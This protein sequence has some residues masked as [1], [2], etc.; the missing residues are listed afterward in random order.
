MGRIIHVAIS[1]ILVVAVAAV[2]FWGYQE[3]Q[4]KNSVL[5]QAENNYQRAFHELNN[6]IGNLE[7]ELGK[8]IA[9]NS[10]KLMAPCM[11]NIWRL[12]YVAQSNIGQLPLNLMAF[13][14]T[15]EFLADI[16]DYTY[17]IGMR[18]LEQEP[19][20]DK[21]WQR[22]K[23]LHSQS[24][25]IKS[26]LRKVQ[27][28]VLDEGLRWMDVEVALA[29][30][31]ADM[32]KG[33]VQGFEGLEEQVQGYIESENDATDSKSVNDMTDR[34]KISG[35]DISAKEA[36]QRVRDFLGIKKA[37]MEVEEHDD[38]DGVSIYS[39]HIK[40]GKN[41]ISVDVSKKGGHVVW[42]LNSR[43]VKEAKIGLHEAQNKA[44]SFLEKRDLSSLEVIET[45]QYDN[46]GVFE[47]VRQKEDV[48]IYPENITVKVALDNGHVIGYHA[49]D[50]LV[51]HQKDLEVPETKVT[52]DEAKQ[53][54]NGNLQVMEDHLAMIEV[55]EEE[56]ALCYELLGTIE[57]ETYRVFV[58]AETGEEER[59]EK[60][61]QAQP[62]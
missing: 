61:K 57:N 31:D 1:A 35:E 7:D 16:A 11:T 12:S 54:V 10:R 56:Y 48:R 59:V 45:N 14:K 34:G 51:N 27:S 24:K 5:I 26:E 43:N 18:D 60:M 9:M 23:T 38:E 49:E 39:V 13:S 22:L 20:S 50:Y 55:K 21:E 6:N 30:E 41:T 17:D 47:F 19:L 42:F 28:Q 33:I 44:L 36:Q 52:L 53:N 3:H 40:D 15:K 46:V 58:N 29:S 32:D 62:L 2:G 37:E 8:S 4:D 25:E